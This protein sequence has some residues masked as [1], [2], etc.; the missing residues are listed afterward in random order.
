MRQ[1]NNHSLRIHLHRATIC[2]RSG[3]ELARNL[4]T[5]IGVIVGDEC[6]LKATEEEQLMRALIM[7]TSVRRASVSRA[8]AKT[9]LALGFA[10]VMAG[11]SI[12]PA[13]AFT[14]DV[15]GVHVHVGPHRHYWGPR[16][17]GYAPGYYDYAPCPRGFTVQD[18]VC[19]PY[20]GY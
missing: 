8:F 14:I 10:V 18:G 3:A 19:K 15:P 20:R 9:A 7:R 11:A 16:H 12:M 6:S 4:Q 5:R 1:L 2:S 17:Y 13:N